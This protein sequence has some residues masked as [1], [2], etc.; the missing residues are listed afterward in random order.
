MILDIDTY[1]L[2]GQE[3]LSTL[4][5]A[6]HGPDSVPSPRNWAFYRQSLPPE[7]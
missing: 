1:T 7:S 4:K 3:D 5:I 2:S 6:L